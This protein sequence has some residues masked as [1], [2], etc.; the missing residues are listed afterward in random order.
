MKDG[1]GEIILDPTWLQYAMSKDQAEMGAPG[2]EGGA[3]GE[4]GQNKTF[5]DVDF[6]ALLNEGNDEEDQTGPSPTPDQAKAKKASTKAAN[7]G[8]AKPGKP[9]QPDDETQKSM[10]YNRLYLDVKL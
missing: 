2:E 5:G 9:G 7:E 8:P 4:D 6:E 1:K 3:P 10:R